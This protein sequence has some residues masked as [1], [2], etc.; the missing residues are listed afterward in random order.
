M[1]KKKHILY[2]LMLMAAINISCREAFELQTENFESVLVVETTITNELKY[3]NIKLSRT[4]PLEENSEP[5]IENDANVFITDNLNNTYNFFQSTDGIYVSDIEF[6]AEPNR[7]YTLN[8]VTNDDTTFTS[9]TT[10]LTPISQIDN[11]YPEY[12]V[13]EAGEESI[14]VLVDSDNTST[15]AK[16]F[17]YEY[18]ETYKIVAPFHS[19]FDIS[20]D[21]YTIL[22]GIQ[23]YD[24]IIT[25]RAQEERICFSS[26]IQTDIIQYTTS[27]L[28]ENT[29]SRFPVKILETNASEIRSRYSILV[30]Q[31]SQDIEA[32]IFY[33]TLNDLGN[34][35]SIL[36]QSQPG[37]V[38]GNIES[39]NSNARVIGFFEVSAVDKKRV[40]FSSADFG[41]NDPPYFFECDVLDL[42]YLDAQTADVD[43]DP[44][45]RNLLYGLVDFRDY[46]LVF[47]SFPNYTI[48]NPE[49]GDC[50][51]FSSNIQPDFWED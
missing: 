17:R 8:I 18:E 34:I 23:T 9:S 35:E 38:F 16:Y 13:N 36:S 30:K 11:L 15:G 25:P 24:I 40:Y 1:A 41:L 50:T 33:R 51:T 47:S 4:Y 7:F 27:I 21:N 45:E 48:V 37:F 19:D 32:F 26:R 49:C 20:F 29:I 3:Q 12:I 43:G 42:N 28:N 22:N 39:T 2:V 5:A 44:D 46:K 6:K 14:Q 31:Y 10:T